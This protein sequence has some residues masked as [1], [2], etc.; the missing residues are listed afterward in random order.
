MKFFKEGEKNQKCDTKRDTESAEQLQLHQ[1]SH[2][3]TTERYL[4]S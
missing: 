3:R 2:Q 4:L 1:K